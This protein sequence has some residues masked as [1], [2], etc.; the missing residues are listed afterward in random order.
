[1]GG[2]RTAHKKLLLGSQNSEVAVG[3]GVFGQVLF[4]RPALVN[5]LWYSG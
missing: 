5:L 2:L 1:M 4:S 3:Y